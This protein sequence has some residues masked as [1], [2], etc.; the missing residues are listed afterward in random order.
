MDWI[1]PSMWAEQSLLLSI[2]HCW[3][4]AAGSATR[5]ALINN[6][7]SKEVSSIMCFYS[8]RYAQ[9]S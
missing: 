7:H 5:V 6:L 3:Q 9:N 1:P 4:L 2:L 8:S